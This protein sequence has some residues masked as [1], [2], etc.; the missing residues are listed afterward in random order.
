[1]TTNVS[2]DSCAWNYLFEHQVNIAE[3]FPSDEY[4]LSVTREVEIE[5]SEIPDKA[6]KQALK[7]YIAES[8]ATHNVQTTSVFGFAEA[9]SVK[10]DGTEVHVYGGFG[11]GTFESDADRDWYGSNDVKRLLHDKAKRPTGLGNDEADASLA[12]RSF[13]SIILTKESPMKKGPLFL[14]ATQGGRIVYLDEIEKSGLSLKEYIA[15]IV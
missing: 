2:I 5:L 6:D 11:Q 1:M 3:V 4:T 9:C 7:V 10:Q 15:S 8:I 12:V 13:D 14:A